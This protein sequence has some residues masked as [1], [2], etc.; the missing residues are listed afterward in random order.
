M[1]L[2][3]AG[4]NYAGG[5]HWTAIANNVSI[6]TNEP[7]GYTN[8]L[9]KL[10]TNQ[11]TVAGRTST[12]SSSEEAMPDLLRGLR[13]GVTQRDMLACIPSK[14]ETDLLVD[15]Y[16]ESLEASICMLTQLRGFGV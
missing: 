12:C 4:A 9:I 7:F 3:T 8:E 16:F 15:A 14:P 1:Q 6:L 5:E 2:L 11:D 13:A 10:V